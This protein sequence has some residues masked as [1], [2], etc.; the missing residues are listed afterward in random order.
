VLVLQ[1]DV[2]VHWL[3]V[4]GAQHH[5]PCPAPHVWHVPAQHIF[6]VLPLHSANWAA[7]VPT[8]GPPVWQQPPFAHVVPPPSTMQHACPAP[9][10]GC[11]HVPLLHVPPFMHVPLFAT[12]EPFVSQQPPFVHE[13]PPQHVWP[14][15]PH[16]VHAPL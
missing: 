5:A 13:V 9:P 10:H 8:P 14:A 15:V 7:Q 4:M 2:L 12:H 1:P 3:G 11:P 16:A 6:P